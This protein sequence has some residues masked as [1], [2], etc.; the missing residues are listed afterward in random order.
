MPE[1]DPSYRLYLEEKFLGIQTQ[2]NAHFKASNDLLGEINSHVQLTNSRVTHNE[3]VI[4]ELKIAGV[5]HIIECPVVPK[6]T[7]IEEDLAEYRFFKKYPKLGLMIILMCLVI[8]GMTL[9][10]TFDRG[11]IKNDLKEYNHQIVITIDSL[12]TFN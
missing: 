8:F 11:R 1:N 4:E 6:V 2:I 9:Y 3:D 7:K 5:K 12:K 10:G